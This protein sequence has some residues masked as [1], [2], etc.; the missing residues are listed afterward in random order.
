MALIQCPECKKK[1]SDTATSC[2]KCGWQLTPEKVQKIREDEKAR[3]LGCLVLTGVVVVLIVVGSLLSKNGP[4]KEASTQAQSGASSTVALTQK[5]PFDNA[6]VYPYDLLKNPYDHKNR[7]VILAPMSWPIIFNGQV[8]QY[9][10][11]HNTG[12]VQLGYS[13]L[14]LERMTSDRTAL[15]NIM[16]HSVNGPTELELMGQLAVELLPSGAQLDT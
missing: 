16:G 10:E 14:R 15:Y 4:P 2:P 13:G 5:P 6:T 7:L 8:I 3:N 9:T 12:M 1:V 11:A